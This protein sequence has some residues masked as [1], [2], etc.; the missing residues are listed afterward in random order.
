M[1]PLHRL[2]CLCISLDLRGRDADDGEAF[3]RQVVAL[4]SDLG[5]ESWGFLGAGSLLHILDSQVS[6][7]EVGWWVLL[8]C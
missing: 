3:R 8:F 4:A 6:V 5:G 1:E 2:L 7:Y